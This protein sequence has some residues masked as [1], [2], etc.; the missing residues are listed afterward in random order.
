MNSNTAPHD[1]QNVVKATQGPFS[2]KLRYLLAVTVILQFFLIINSSWRAQPDAALYLELGESLAA[3]RGYVFNNE[4]HTY[5]PPAYPALIALV[6][7]LLGRDLLFYRILMSVLGL[8]TGLLA[9]M[10][11]RRLCGSETALLLGGFCITSH[12]LLENSTITCSDTLFAFSVFLAFHALLSL[13]VSGRR[14][15]ALATAVCGLAAGLPALVRINGWGVAPALAFYMAHTNRDASLPRR[16]GQTALFLAAAVAPAAAW[17]YYKS[18]FPKSCNEGTYVNAVLGRDISTQISVML[19]SLKDYAYEIT[20]AC[21]GVSIKTGVLELVIP[22]LILLGLLRLMWQGERLFGPFVLIQMAG[23]CLSPAGSRYLIALLPGFAIF[24]AEGVAFARE[25]LAHRVRGPLSLLPPQ[26]RLGPLLF[27]TLIFLNVGANM[28]TIIQA[29]SALEPNGAE[30]YRDKPFF[31]ASRWLRQH[32]HEGPV[33]TMHPR[34]IHYLSGLPTVE[35]V[36][37]GVPENKAFIDSPDE[38]TRVIA[39][40][41]PRYFFSDAKN[42]TMKTRVAEALEKM[43]ATLEEI[44]NIDPGRRFG[45]WKILYP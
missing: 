33:L 5:A 2:T 36:R 22:L 26:N 27:V 31:E 32:A 14:G 13:G 20:Y 1:Y 12:A 37:S 6:N 19:N 11:I 42:S 17:E 9:Y 10:L 7:V 18:F 4:P 24:L 25:V 16:A 21:T 28:L 29:R 41:R 39:L 3:G 8:F 45:L 40:T 30:S 35:L 43:G 15:W 38:I 34:V 23:L 44:P